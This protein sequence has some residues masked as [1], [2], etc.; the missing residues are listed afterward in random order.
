MRLIQR[1]STHLSDDLCRRTCVVFDAANPPR[2]RPHQFRIS[3]IDVRFAVGYPEAD[4]L[5]QELISSHSAPKGLAVVSSD[6]RVQAAARRRSCTVFDAQPWLDE[7]LE[8]R[9]RLAVRTRGGSARGSA[10][11]RSGQDGGEQ[12]GGEL[13]SHGQGVGEQ[14]PSELGTSDR[15]GDLDGE[16]V[17]RW[18]REFGF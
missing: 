5:L 13:G 12:D 8:G 10:G 17:D 15:S 14:G 7:L 4:D 6:H 16:Q 2:D 11:G 9:A 18:L 3:G 1:L